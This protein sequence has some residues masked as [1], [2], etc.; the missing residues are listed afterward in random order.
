MRLAV[1]AAPDSWYL[2]DLQRAAGNDHEVVGLSFSQLTAEV[3]PDA[4]SVSCDTV[5]LR[6]CDTVALRDC[7]T[8][9]LR[10][11][12]AVLVRSMPPGSL[13]QVVF[14]MNALAQLEHLGVP[15]I[16]SPRSLETAID[17]YRCAAELQFLPHAP[18]SFVCQTVEEALRGQP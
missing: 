14:R 15:V 4:K 9:A 10:D 2:K 13:E 1:L 5:T 12:D 6:D 7:D 18:R 3:R 11:F 8:V 16:N 17:K